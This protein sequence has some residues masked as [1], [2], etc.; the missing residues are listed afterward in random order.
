MSTEEIHVILFL[1]V[2]VYLLIYF[3]WSVIDFKKEL[4]RRAREM[5][6]FLESLQPG[7]VFVE[8]ESSCWD[9]PFEEE[10]QPNTVRVIETRSNKYGDRWVKYQI[11][12]SGEILSCSAQVFDGVF[13]KV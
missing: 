2:I 5:S 12:C 7:N 4:R 6:V 9:N 1:F 8:R 10:Y 13:K 11:D 3:V